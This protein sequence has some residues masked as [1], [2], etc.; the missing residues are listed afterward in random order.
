MNEPCFFLKTCATALILLASLA[1]PWPSAKAATL[2][3]DYDLSASLNDNVGTIALTSNGGSLGANGLAFGPD[4]GPSLVGA[5]NPA[6][7]SIFMRFSLDAT[8]GWRRLVDFKNRTTDN[9]LYNYGN[10]LQFVVN[11]G[12]DFVTGAA[13]VF[14]PGR[15]V[16]L[17]ITRDAASQQFIGYVDGIQQI[18]FTDS[19]DGAV[20]DPT[21]DPIIQFLRDDLV[22]SG[23]SGSGVLKTIRI[24]QGV[25]SQ[26][27]VAA[28]SVPL[29]AAVWLFG[30]AVAGLGWLGTGRGRR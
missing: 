24:Y 29:P 6:T 8:D 4:Q 16:D 12:F 10:K 9:G 7:Y 5:I 23:E 19:A 1:S 22:V 14:A 15:T 17:A 2:I 18:S 11:S 27:E 30:P 3:H 13:D 20:F 26:G 21:S 25:L 28:L